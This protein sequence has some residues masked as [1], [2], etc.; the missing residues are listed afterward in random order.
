M[1]RYLGIDYGA[2]RIGVA[3][4]DIEGRIAFPRMTIQ[5][6]GIPALIKKLET[7][8]AEENISRIVVGL[9]IGLDGKETEQTRVMQD[10]IEKLRD[11][12]AIPIEVENEM[13]TTRI[14]EQTSKN[15]VDESS[16]AVILQ[17]YLDRIAN[18]V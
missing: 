10:L 7:V 6:R 3:I 5:N 18:R 9:P 17:T 8:V 15:K 12:I 4:S 16:A 13:L 11:A 2:K 1:M 14:A